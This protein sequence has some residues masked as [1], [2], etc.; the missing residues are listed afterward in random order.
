MTM[1][2]ISSSQHYGQGYNI[3]TDKPTSAQIMK[4]ET[5]KKEFGFV[6]PTRAKV[7]KVNQT[8]SFLEQF[9]D[10]KSYVQSRLNN[11]NVSLDVQHDVFNMGARAGFNLSLSKSGSD[12]SSKSGLSIFCEHRMFNVKI[13]NFKEENNGI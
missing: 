9:K 6:L 12:E 7:E 13:A 3:L 4:F 2:T 10:K 8:Q 5:E 11:L 1:R